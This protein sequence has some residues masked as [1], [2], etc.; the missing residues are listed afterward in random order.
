MKIRQVTLLLIIISLLIHTFVFSQD[1]LRKDGRYYVADIT[2]EFDVNKSGELV[3]EDITGDIVI[4][5]WDKGQVW[6]HEVRRM[7]VYTKKE[8]EA[9]FEDAK[10]IYRQNG[11]TISVQGDR[12]FRSHASSNFEIKLPAQFSVDIST[13]GGDI[14]IEKLEGKADLSTSGGDID[15]KEVGGEVDARTSGGDIAV[16]KSSSE[17]DVKTSGGDIDII[18]VLGEVNAKTSGGDILIRNNKAKVSARTS[19]GDIEMQNVGE[20]VEAMTSGGDIEVLGSAGD[21]EVSTSGGDLELMNIKGSAKGSTSGGDIEA[22]EVENG[23][24]VKTSGGDIELDQIHGFIEASTSG[25][26]IEAEMT[27]KA[28]SKDH[29]V[30]LK[31]SGGDLTLYIPAKLNATI[32]AEI[33]LHGSWGGRDSRY[34]IVSDFDLKKEK[35]DKDSRDQYIRAQGKI[36]GGGDLIYLHTNNGNIRI[37]KTR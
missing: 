30:E 24:S 18:D 2:K 1:E 29:H 17:V 32:N 6:I 9:I 28:M 26:D 23:I 11:N 36:N 35:S 22:S 15:L 8:A 31:S 33:K 21:I 3:M 20:Q 14:S 27:D 13:S 12:G 10:K 5:T 37:K 7:D 4:T 34:D 19:G 16:I 25:G